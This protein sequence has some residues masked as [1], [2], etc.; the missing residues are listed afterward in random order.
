MKRKVIQL[1]GK[2]LVVSIPTVWAKKYNIKKGDEID[3]EE[4]KNKLVISPEKELIK[5]KISLDVSGLSPMIYRILG[6]VYKAGYDEVEVQFGS[7]KDLE[8]IEEVAKREFIGFEIVRKGKNSVLIKSVSEI[9]YRE[10]DT[11]L[12]RT[13]LIVLEIAE[14]GLESMKAYD[15]KALLK[16]I[17][18]DKEVNKY[19]DFCRRS[20]NKKGYASFI[21][22]PTIYFIVE[23]LEKVSDVYRDLCKASVELD[24][25]LNKD[26]EQIFKEVNMFFREFYELFY[27]FDLNKLAMHGRRRFALIKS[28]NDLMK[29]VSKEELIL[30]FFLSLI[31]EDVFNMNGALIASK[32]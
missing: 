29:K 30:V 13:F 28:L 19:A 31:V 32:I 6:A 8:E 24:N 3:L 2:T 1:A 7:E 9:D 22:T 20:L 11:M 4:I 10:F 17:E 5:E 26:I 23:E 18:L 16:L 27:K 14:E 21:K 15:K 25:K 12:R